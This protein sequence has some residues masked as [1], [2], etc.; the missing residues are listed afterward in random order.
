MQPLTKQFAFCALFLCLGCSGAPIQPSD[1]VQEYGFYTKL[2]TDKANIVLDV[3]FRNNTT[4][5]IEIGLGF[6]NCSFRYD[7]QVGNTT[8]IYP[9]KQTALPKSTALPNQPGFEQTCPA[10]R[11][12][13]IVNKCLTVRLQELRLPLSL[14]QALHTAK[15]KYYGE[16]RLSYQINQ[17][18]RLETYRIS[19]K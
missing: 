18:L 3:F 1:S 4:K 11:H 15:M 10:M 12:T 16:F 17:E 19:N 9:P 2:R 7:F 14:T 8:Y 13:R 5:S 6:W